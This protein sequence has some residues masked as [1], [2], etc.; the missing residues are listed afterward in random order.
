MS[1]YQR[2]FI[3]QLHSYGGICLGLFCAAHHHAGLLNEEE[4][5]QAVAR[6]E[7]T[8][9]FNPGTRI[10]AELLAEGPQCQN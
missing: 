5:E 2:L 8:E 10:T 4:Y 6:I 9:R 1:P 7:N 3:A